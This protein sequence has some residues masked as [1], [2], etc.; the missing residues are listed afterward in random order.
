MV[1]KGSGL[2]DF[3]FYI[4]SLVIGLIIGVFLPSYSKQK[5]INLATKEDIGKITEITKRVESE[6]QKINIKYD[7]E[8]KFSSQYSSD[9]YIN[10]YHLIYAII[11]QSE[12]FKIIEGDI[13]NGTEGE[14]DFS[15]FEE[16]PFIAISKSKERITFSREGTTTTSEQITDALTNANLKNL[17]TL[18]IENGQHSSQELLKLA[19]YLRYLDSYFDENEKF[20]RDDKENE[21]KFNTQRLFI[22]AEII[23]LSVK[24]YNEIRRNLNLSYSE[25]EL[26]N[27]LIEHAISIK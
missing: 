15:N 5:G 21:D 13:L 16:Y 8:I 26:K 11:I 14:K 18:I 4:I 3:V 1:L 6:F 2:M 7:T 12:F 27:G 19:I 17:Y 25:Y 9:R 10:L 20:K 23:K 24:E 22:T